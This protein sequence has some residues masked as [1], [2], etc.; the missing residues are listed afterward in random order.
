MKSKAQTCQY[1]ANRD[2][3]VANPYCIYRDFFILPPSM[4]IVSNPITSSDCKKCKC[5][6]HVLSEEPCENFSKVGW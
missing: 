4:R 1:N 3:K 5:Y 6:K 2:S